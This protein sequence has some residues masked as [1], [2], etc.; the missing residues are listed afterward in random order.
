LKVGKNPIGEILIEII[1][2]LSTQN[3]E[4]FMVLQKEEIVCSTNQV[5]DNGNMVDGKK[6]TI[7]DI[8][9][10]EFEGEPW[11]LFSDVRRIIGVNS[12][13]LIKLYN[14]DISFFDDGSVVAISETAL[15]AAVLSKIVGDDHLLYLL[16][17]KATECRKLKTDAIS[18]RHVN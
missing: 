4:F 11:F 7:R 9:I 17:E 6:E 10:I 18:L 12:D 16:A 5:T 13:F 2:G 15:Y 8:A 1:N 3:K 14:D